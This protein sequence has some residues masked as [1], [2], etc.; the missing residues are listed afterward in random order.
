MKNVEKARETRLWITQVIAPLTIA[1]VLI[2]N[3]CPNVRYFV[4]DKANKTKQ[5]V[6]RVFKREES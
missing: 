4:A 3:N 5:L 1:G 6:K 2:W